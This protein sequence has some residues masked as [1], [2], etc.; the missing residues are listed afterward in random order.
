M[1]DKLHMK[2]LV[3]DGFGTLFDL[4]SAAPAFE[5]VAPGQG[6]EVLR[7]WRAKQLQ[8]TRRCIITRH[9]QNLWILMGQAMD[10]A[11]LHFRLDISTTKRLELCEQY[12][13][14]KVFDEVPKVLP[15]LKEKYKLVILSH[16]TQLMLDAVTAHNQITHLFDNILSVDSV[17]A[18]KP[19][20][21]SY[22]LVRQMINLPESSFD[23]IG[24]N[25][26]DIAGAR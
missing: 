18:Y 26:M 14:L 8:Y 25:P 12:L 10:E 1:L 16:G 23:Y 11:C 7:W 4:E 24:V 5:Q 3:F 6:L 9:Y 17:Q 19:E 21:K 22:A 20:L 2:V 15:K 13:T